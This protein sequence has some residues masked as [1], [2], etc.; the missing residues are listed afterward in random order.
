MKSK[1]VKLLH[2]QLHKAYH[3]G[4]IPKD[5]Y[6]QILFSLKKTHQQRLEILEKIAFI[7]PKRKEPVSDLEQKIV[8]LNI[9]LVEKFGDIDAVTAIVEKV[10]NTIAEESKE[11]DLFNGIVNHFKYLAELLR[12]NP[13]FLEIIAER[14]SYKKM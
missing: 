7:M 12:E 9:M 11:K 4:H 8:E 2:D 3:G 6:L 10:F 13:E 5:V 14:N 1:S